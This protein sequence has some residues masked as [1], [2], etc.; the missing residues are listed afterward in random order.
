MNW[1]KNIS[2][3]NTLFELKEDHD[4]LG[5]KGWT[6]FVAEFVR[7]LQSTDLKYVIS[8]PTFTGLGAGAGIACFVVSDEELQMLFQPLEQTFQEY[9]KEIEDDFFKARNEKE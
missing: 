8:N 6:F 5:V 4:T 9:E 2:K 7:D 3:W 1:T